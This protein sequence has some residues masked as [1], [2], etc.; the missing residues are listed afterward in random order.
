MSVLRMS[1]GEADPGFILTCPFVNMFLF[2]ELFCTSLHL[3]EDCGYFYTSASAFCIFLH[4]LYCVLL[5]FSW[6]L[7]CFVLS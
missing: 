6:L 1:L 3:S 4:A 2:L 7:R 5:L